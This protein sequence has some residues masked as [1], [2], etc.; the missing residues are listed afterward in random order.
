[1]SY[2]DKVLGTPATRMPPAAPQR[3]T[4]TPAASPLWN[5]GQQQPAPQ[6]MPQG[7]ATGSYE[8]A[9]DD[10]GQVAAVQGFI[11]KPPEWVTKQPQDTCPECGGVNFA[12]HGDS[13]GTYGK[14][15]RTSVGQVEFGHCFDCGYTENGGHPQSD[16]QI[17]NS[18]S[19]GAINNGGSVERTR[20]PHGMQNFFEI[21]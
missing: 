12:L 13:E 15:R 21:K 10:A 17:G 1:M 18:H 8:R 2:W 5:S 19:H 9:T 16:S 4:T 14:L 20:Q 7:L 6:G 3:A 11:K